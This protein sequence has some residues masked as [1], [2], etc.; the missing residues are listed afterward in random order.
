MINTKLINSEH[1]CEAYNSFETVYSDHRII[2]AIFKLNFRAN[3][4]MN[5]N[6]K[7][8]NWSLLYTNKDLQKKFYTDFKRKFDT[9]TKYIIDC[10]IMYQAFV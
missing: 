6:T 4:N 3:T 7:P 2:T 8:Y 5:K 9:Y 1:N 10:N